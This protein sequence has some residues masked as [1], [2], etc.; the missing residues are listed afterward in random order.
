M[1]QALGKDDVAAVLVLQDAQSDLKRRSTLEELAWCVTN[2]LPPKDDLYSLSD[3]TVLSPTQHEVVVS[4]C[5]DA[6]NQPLA[7]ASDDIRWHAFK[8]AYQLG[9]LRV[10]AAVPALLRM[11][12]EPGWTSY[13]VFQGVGSTRP[14]MA[15]WALTQIADPS[16]LTALREIALRQS[17]DRQVPYPMYTA[18]LLA[19]SRLAKE[20]AIDD[21]TTILNQAGEDRFSSVAHNMRTYD[22]PGA[23]ERA[24]AE[25]PEAFPEFGTSQ[26]A[27][28]FALAEIGGPRARAALLAYLASDDS[29]RRLTSTIVQALYRVAP[30]QLDEWAQRTLQTPAEWGY[31]SLRATAV[32]VRLGY[33]PAQAAPLARSIL[34]DPA[35]PLRWSI[36]DLLRTRSFHDQVVTAA[37]VRLLDG[38]VTPSLR[39]DHLSAFDHRLEVLDAVGCQGGDEVVQTLLNVVEHGPTADRSR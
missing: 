27:A 10:E 20:E 7:H 24:Y 17:S 31:N 30:E 22:L 18:A 32:A 13:M 35:H 21:L 38:P 2:G 12:E 14:S 26:E 28:A 4:L 29:K 39:G 25:V 15:G 37:L 19:Y 3:D 11:L 23:Q 16:C 1:R 34:D 9:R 6:I 8:A 36:V 33:F 5:L